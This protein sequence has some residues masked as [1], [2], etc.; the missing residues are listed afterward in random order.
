MWTLVTLVTVSGDDHVRVEAL[1]RGKPAILMEPATA[2]LVGLTLLQSMLGD[3]GIC[4][5][6][7]RHHFERD[8]I[9]EDND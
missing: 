4:L 6:T 2:F 7:R 8:I 1:K 9:D 5:V 3:S